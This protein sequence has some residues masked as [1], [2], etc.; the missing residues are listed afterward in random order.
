M[1]MVMIV[2]NEALDNELMEILASAGQKNYTKQSG[3]FGRGTT[4]GIHLGTD[5]WPGLNNIL[6]LATEDEAAKKIIA[7]VRQ[8]R[9]NIGVEGAKAFLLP[10]ED[11]T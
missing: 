1:K 6:Y 8:L 11:L 3:V 7:A 4:S 10:I 2:Y 5:I 9:K